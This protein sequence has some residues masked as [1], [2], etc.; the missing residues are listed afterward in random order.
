MVNNKNAVFLITNYS[1]LSY[2]IAC[3]NSIERFLRGCD[4]YIYCEDKE[5]YRCLRLLHRYI[6]LS[7][8]KVKG[9]VNYKVHKDVPFF[10]VYYKY[11]LFTDIFDDYENVLYLDSDVIVNKDITSFVFNTKDFFVVKN[12][13]YSKEVRILNPFSKV[14]L[15]SIGLS[16]KNY[17]NIK[18]MINAGVMLVPKKYRNSYYYESLIDITNKLA[19]FL[20]YGDQSALSLWCLRHNIKVSEDYG[21]NYQMPV[22]NKWFMPRYKNIKFYFFYNKNVVND[23]SIIHYSGKVK[24]PDR[25]F[26]KWHLMGRYNKLFYHLMD[27]NLYSIQ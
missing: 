13:F 26:L 21:Y 20:E 16:I 11:L 12:N 10:I 18:D 23:I 7:N 8:M 19:D 27:E 14:L 5:S 9:L 4:I 15:D 1:Y 6:L 22:Y 17:N 3:L 25:R 24:P 2:T